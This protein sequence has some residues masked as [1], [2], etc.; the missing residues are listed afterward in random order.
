MA[1]LKQLLF[2]LAFLA[3]LGGAASPLKQHRLFRLKNKSATSHSPCLIKT[4]TSKAQH[5]LPI[6]FYH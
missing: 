3:L 6:I 2:A 5:L 1:W 4:T